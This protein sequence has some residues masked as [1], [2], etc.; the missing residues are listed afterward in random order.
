MVL[1]HVCTCTCISLLIRC[2][3][4]VEYCHS[5]PEHW[6]AYWCELPLAKF[7]ELDI[8]CTCV[9]V[10]FHVIEMYMFRLCVYMYMYIRSVYLLRGHVDTCTC[11]VHVLCSYIYIVHAC[12]CTCT[13][14]HVQCTLYCTSHIE[15][16]YFL[17]VH[18]SA[19]IAEVCTCR[20]DGNSIWLV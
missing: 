6:P 19:I 17:H 16:P 20:K 1:L 18:I 15:F 2:C 10:H 14:I 9:H 3:S 8:H 5:S 11:T 4:W 12:T 7:V 13:S